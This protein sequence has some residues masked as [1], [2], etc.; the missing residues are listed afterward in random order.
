VGEDRRL[1]EE[2]LQLLR[3]APSVGAGGSLVQFLHPRSA[4]GVLLEIAEPQPATADAHLQ[5]ESG[6]GS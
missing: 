5:R 2:G 1:R 3:E 4:G 6:E